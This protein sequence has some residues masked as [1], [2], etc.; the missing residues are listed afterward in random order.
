MSLTVASFKDVLKVYQRESDTRIIGKPTMVMMLKEIFRIAKEPSINFS[1]ITFLV[2][3]QDLS[4]TIDAY[5]IFHKQ[6]IGKDRFERDK[7]GSM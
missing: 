6:I 5:D 3:A 4:V 7:S 1:N 2:N